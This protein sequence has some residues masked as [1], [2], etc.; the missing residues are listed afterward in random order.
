MV[1]LAQL[2]PIVKLVVL[3]VRRS[4]RSPATPIYTV[5]DAMLEVK[6]RSLH[7]WRAWERGVSM[8]RHA[9]LHVFFYFFFLGV[10]MEEKAAMSWTP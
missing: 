5:R 9:S 7:E 4:W 6:A 10:E 2:D 3:V 8:L 1:A